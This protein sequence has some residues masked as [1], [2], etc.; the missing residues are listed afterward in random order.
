MLLHRKRGNA[1]VERN[2]LI[3]AEATVNMT[4]LYKLVHIL[5]IDVGSF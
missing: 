2:D 4:R 3:S 1:N 5:T